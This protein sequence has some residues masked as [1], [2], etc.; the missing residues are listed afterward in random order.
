[1][2]TC[3]APLHYRAILK[4]S[5]T[6]QRWLLCPVST[7]R[8]LSSRD[9]KVATTNNL[10]GYYPDQTQRNLSGSLRSNFLPNLG[11]PGFHQEEKD[12]GIRRRRRNSQETRR[13]AKLRV[14]KAGLPRIMGMSTAESPVSSSPVD[15]FTTAPAPTA[16]VS[17]SID[18][19]FSRP[20]VPPSMSS[21]R[22]DY[23][24]S[25]YS[26]PS[27]AQRRPC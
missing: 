26:W 9:E 18:R 17:G 27:I 24:H 10:A 21:A 12:A 7:T 19:S 14:R 2:A 3:L 16:Y 11:F 4:A 22:D 1:M 20:S 25:V 23:R 13:Q 6:P 8:T 15:F 5:L